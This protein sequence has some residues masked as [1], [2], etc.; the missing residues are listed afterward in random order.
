MPPINTNN[1]KV[2]N[3]IN[4]KTDLKEQLLWITLYEEGMFVLPL[5]HIKFIYKNKEGKI[6]KWNYA[7]SECIKYGCRTTLDTKSYYIYGPSSQM[8]K[9]NTLKRNTCSDQLFKTMPDI[10]F[11]FYDINV[12][13]NKK[14][15]SRV[16][17]LT[18]EPEDYMINTNELGID[19]DDTEMN[20]IPGFGTTGTQF[21]WN[22]GIM[23]MKKFLIAYDFEE[24]RMG[25]VRINDEL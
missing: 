18:L 20:C 21:G 17:T 2:K 9:I 6:I 10:E 7:V 3:S 23:F 12:N 24:E 1:Q 25:F 16:L 8:T 5:R 4:K 22:L 15:T 13:R 14:I 19:G 11:G